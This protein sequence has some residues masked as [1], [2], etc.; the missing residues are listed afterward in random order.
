MFLGGKILLSYESVKPCCGTE[1][2]AIFSRSL[3]SM[4]CEYLLVEHTNTG[5]GAPAQAVD[6][7]LK[8]LLHM[9]ISSYC[10]KLKSWHQRIL[11]I[12]V[13]LR[14]MR[15]KWVSIPHNWTCNFVFHS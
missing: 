14:W 1:N 7:S 9:V 10:V 8:F 2:V 12:P 5:P 11:E 6:E 15:Y 3:Y 4:P 13:F